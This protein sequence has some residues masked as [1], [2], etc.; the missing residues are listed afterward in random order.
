MQ[1]FGMK[2][3]GGNQVRFDYDCDAIPNA[4]I[5][6]GSIQRKTGCNKLRNQDLQYLDRHNVACGTDEVMQDWYI[7]QDTCG[8]DDMRIMYNCLPVLSQTCG[9]FHTGCNA[10][11]GKEIIYLDRHQVSCPTH[12]PYL[13]RWQ[14]KPDGCSSGNMR[15]EY[16]CC[17]IQKTPSDWVWFDFDATLGQQVEYTVQAS[18]AM[19]KEGCSSLLPATIQGYFSKPDAATTQR[20]KDAAW[21]KAFTA[22]VDKWTPE[23]RMKAEPLDARVFS[24]PFHG[25]RRQLYGERMLYGDDSL[26]KTEKQLRDAIKNNRWVH[27]IRKK[28]GNGTA[29]A[30]AT[31]RLIFMFGDRACSCSGSA[32]RNYNSPDRSIIVTAAH[33]IYD[34][35]AKLF[36]SY[37]L[38]VPGID[39]GGKGVSNRDCSDD[40]FGCWVPEFA[41]VDSEWASV[42]VLIKP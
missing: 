5:R 29:M 12:Q 33:C 31:G 7:R 30:Q 6:G 13:K 21:E 41:V 17:S 23:M 8:G 2:G 28:E 37:I 42:S 22:V 15:I 24:D 19:V 1:G 27:D 39:D 40:E 20:I 34:E 10:I 4:A 26:T 32:L 3:C 36:A 9:T 25:T 18:N 14:L 16:D 38:F 35:Q 11:N